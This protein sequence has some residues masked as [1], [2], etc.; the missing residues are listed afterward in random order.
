MTAS[1][2]DQ[3]TW[4]PVPLGGPLLSPEDV[5]SPDVTPTHVTV[6]G[7]PYNAIACWLGS[8]GL[9]SGSEVLEFCGV[10]GA[11]VNKDPDSGWAGEDSQSEE[12]TWGNQGMLPGRGRSVEAPNHN[13][14]RDCK[15]H[16]VWVTGCLTK[17]FPEV[18]TPLM[19]GHSLPQ[20]QLICL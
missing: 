19:T 17:I 18:C 2:L 3:H 13:V 11:G 1:R 4:G 14:R 10:H 6:S 7:S 8:P 20:I 12:E 9:L 5:Y 15:D 16:L